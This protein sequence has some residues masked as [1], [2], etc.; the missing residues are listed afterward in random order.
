MKWHGSWLAAVIYDMLKEW[1]EG[2]EQAE[3]AATVA[4]RIT[5]IRVVSWIDKP[6][7]IWHRKSQISRL[8]RPLFQQQHS[9]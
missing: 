3:I 2:A 9:L 1:R 4:A 6:V 5:E 7:D 8:R